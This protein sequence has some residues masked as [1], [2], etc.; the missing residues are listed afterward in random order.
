MS[1][2]PHVILLGPPPRAATQLRL[3]LS[4]A[5]PGISRSF[6]SVS[7]R[8][9]SP[10]P[11]SRWY[12]D[13]RARI[14]KCIAFG[15]SRAQARR[16]AAVLGVLAEQWR[17]L[18]AG[19]E[20]FLTGPG[21][22]LED[23]KVVWGEMDSFGHVNNAQYIRYAESGRVNWILHFATLD[24]AHRE[25]WTNLM[26]PHGIGLIMKSITA[27]FKFPMTYPDTISVYHRLS[28]EPS[29]STTS[30]ALESIIL[31]HKHRRAAAT[32][33]ENVVVYDY[34]QAAK[35]TVPPFAL[36]LLRETWNLQKEETRRARQK[37]W[38]LIEDV[39]A[40]EKETWDREDAV[41]DMGAAAAKS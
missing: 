22:G 16:A 20:G 35:T 14:G 38:S 21:R 13:L 8:Q 17:P 18:V 36:D 7:H 23:Q 26:K 1:P 25:Q 32:T 39:Q 12:S 27:D 28:K 41:E 9:N 33:E 37:A 31:S 11:P 24:A 40:L 29:S 6:S 10:P 34:Q 15:C 4:Q 3:L 5:A 2:R 19:C 30:L